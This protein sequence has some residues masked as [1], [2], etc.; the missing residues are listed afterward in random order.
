MS[1]TFTKMVQTLSN[2]CT[3][4]LILVKTR[5]SR[6]DALKMTVDSCTSA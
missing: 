3:C 1:P 2:R 5:V 4:K 6:S